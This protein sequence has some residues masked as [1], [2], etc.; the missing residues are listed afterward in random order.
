VAINQTADGDGNGNRTDVH[1]EAV[2]TC[3][4]LG[5]DGICSFYS[6]W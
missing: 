6:W 2:L 3:Q 4:V 1:Q 5:Q